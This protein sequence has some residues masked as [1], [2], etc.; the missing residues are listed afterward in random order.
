MPRAG[1][2]VPCFNQGRYARECVVSIEG[3]TF[4]DL[5][6]VIV[7]DAST[8]DSATLLDALATERIRVVH[9]DHHL[10][11]AAVRNEAVRL[12]G[13]VDYI[14]NL[15]CDDWLSPWYVEKLVTALE[16]HPRAGLAYGT[17]RHFGEV[18]DRPPSW[19]SAPYDP[20]TRFLENRIPGPGALYRAA[21]LRET[22]GWRAAFAPTA[23]DDLDLALQIIDKGWEPLW[24]PDADYYHRLHASSFR[25]DAERAAGAVTILEHHRKGIDE[26][27]GLTRFLEHHV[28]MWL[29]GTIRRRQLRSG[30]PVLSRL[31]RLAP[32]TTL[33]GL[34]GRYLRR[35]LLP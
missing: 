12:L 1:V 7:D 35:D 28:L 30:A 6:T 5:E 17:L 29:R 20:R 19:P 24:V 21:A 8:D 11:R 18:R 14:L 2:I 23:D 33:R 16:A 26:T 3:Q 31:L 9:L 13:Q 15:E 22:E 4:P 32:R 10:G 34:G 27:V 25:S